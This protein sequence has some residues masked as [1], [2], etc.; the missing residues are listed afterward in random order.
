MDSRSIQMKTMI[1][2]KANRIDHRELTDLTKL[3]KAYWR[4]SSEQIEKWNDDLT[5]TPDYIDANKVFKL[6]FEE[7][8]IGYYSYIQIDSITVKLDNMFISPEYIGKEFG[9]FLMEDFLE[10]VK[11]DKI[12]NIIIDSDPNAEGFYKKFGF[13]VIG[14]L[15]SSIEGRYLP[16]MKKQI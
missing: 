3:S 4:Y 7:S 16:I 8:T 2:E 14:K 13:E 5:V 15:E 6:C 1:V 10:R 11:K 12:E 9:K